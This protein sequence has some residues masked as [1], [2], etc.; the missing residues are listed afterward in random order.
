MTQRKRDPRA[1]ALVAQR[2]PADAVSYMP[3]PGRLSLIIKL[4]GIDNDRLTRPGDRGLWC[5]TD[6]LSYLPGDE[7]RFHTST[8]ASRFSIEIARVGARREVVWRRPASGAR[9][10]RHP[11]RRLPGAAS[12][13]TVVPSG[14]RGTGGPATT[15]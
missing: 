10:I 1:E 12:G 3:P 5:Y 13:R 4:V 6:R 15:P 7:V 9:S 8:S 14:S 2:P 11:P